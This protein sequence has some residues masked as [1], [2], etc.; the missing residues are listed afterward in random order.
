[1]VRAFRRLGSVAVVSTSVLLAGAAPVEKWEREARST[2]GSKACSF[3]NTEGLYGFTCSGFYPRTDA[4]GAIVGQQPIGVVGVLHGDGRGHYSADATLSSDYG[5]LPWRLEGDATLDAKR[6][7]LGRVVY[8]TNQLTLDSGYVL[9]LPPATFDFAVVGG[10]EE[11]LGSATAPGLFGDAVP[12][13]A[14]R[15]VRV[16]H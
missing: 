16:Q 7:C 1:M 13:L 3:A 12:R 9:N 11:I 2:G 15:L 4:T 10:G 6:N 5:S 8:T 14:C